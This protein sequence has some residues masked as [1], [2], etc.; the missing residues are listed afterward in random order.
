MVG[1]SNLSSGLATELLER[2]IPVTWLSNTGRFF[3][4]LESTTG[5]NIERQISQFEAHKDI[6]FRLSLSKAFVIAKMKNCRT[7][8]RR[9]NRQRELDEVDTTCD[10]IDKLA[11]KCS[12]ALSTNELLGYEGVASRIY[13]KSLSL[14]LPNDF[15]FDG[16][17][18]RPPRDP[19]NSL[20]SFGYTLLLYEIFTAITSRNLHPYLG[21]M[22]EPRRGHPALA[23]D[24]MEEWRPTIVDTLA[25][26]LCTT[27]QLKSDDFED[28]VEDRGGVYLTRDASK[29]FI[30]KFEKRLRSE[31]QYLSYVDYP[32]TFRESLSF[33]V[34][35]L[36]KAIE[37][38]DPGIYR[39]VLLR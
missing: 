10:A 27:A 30:S 24:L 23:S 7:V 28:P 1:P 2:E 37:N 31:N 20:L 11:D 22:H 4:R 39:P 15:S 5:Y 12:G 14:L 35:A 33:Q 38:C 8:L 19:F 32:L 26:S 21:L 17:T 34:G 6:A 25:M 3:G 36:A 29:L 16:R 9:Y 18:R 13:F